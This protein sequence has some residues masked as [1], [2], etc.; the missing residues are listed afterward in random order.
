MAC[1]DVIADTIAAAD[2]W[3]ETYHH[4]TVEGLEIIRAK[5]DVWA[6][7][8]EYHSILDDYNNGLIEG[9]PHRD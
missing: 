4:L 7:G 5:S 6:E 1:P 8:S 3:M 2:E 9:A